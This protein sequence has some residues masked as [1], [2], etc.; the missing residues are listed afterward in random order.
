MTDTDTATRVAGRAA[1]RAARPNILLLV[2]DQ[3][4]FDC[5]GAT[6]RFAAIR[7]PNLDR[8]AA[9]GAFFE[10]AFTPNPVCAPA[11]QA[12][13]SGL[14][15]D[16]YGGLWNPDFLATPT[17][18]PA[19]GFYTAGLARAGYV[20]SLIGKWNTSLTHRP[21]DFGFARHID[22]DAY[23]QSIAA[24]YGKIRWQE[25]WFGETSPI[26]LKDSKTHWA[27]R[28]VCN[29]IR[30]D[31]EKN[32]PW[33][34]R[35][36]FTDPHLPCRPSDPFASRIDPEQVEPWDSFGDTLEGKPYIQRQQLVNWGLVGKTWADWRQTVAYYYGMIAQ[37]DDAVGLMLDQLAELGVDRETIVIY[38]SD[39]GDLCGG[40]GMIDKHYTLYDD[41]TRVPL[42]IRYPEGLPAGQHIREYVS[43]CLDIGATIADLCGL[44]DVDPG[45]GLSL[46][47]L[48]RGEAQPERDFAV[49]SANGQQFGLFTQ[50]CIRTDQWLYV[51]NL[52][53]TDELYAVESDPGQKANRIQDPDLTSVISGLRKR[54]HEELIRRGDPFARTFWLEGQLLRDRKL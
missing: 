50:R 35:L 48:L 7:T 21:A 25:P 6:G 34:I 33:L 17:L 29:L 49:S 42:I 18:Q 41:V 9:G 10:H 16:S 46:A 36:D 26:A 2:A 51:W 30:Q 45:L 5:L 22:Y 32:R 23:Q 15:P 13:L 24:Q 27:A 40:H 14:S 52:T 43:S 39:H 38:T 11:R 54:L 8:L 4:R 53:D 19:P 3:H 20:C 44:T 12:L 37:I 28:E 47:P 1:G 31:T